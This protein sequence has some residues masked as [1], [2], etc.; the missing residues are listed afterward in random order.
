MGKRGGV[1]VFVRLGFHRARRAVGQ[2]VP[3]IGFRVA[4]AGGNAALG[5]DILDRLPRI[6]AVFRIDLRERI[7]T[8]QAGGRAGTSLRALRRRDVVRDAQ[9][10]LVRHSADPLRAR[11]VV[12]RVDA[13]A[14]HS[15]RPHYRFHLPP[16]V[17]PGGR[18]NRLRV[19]ERGLFR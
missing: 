14:V 16:I 9:L 8:R 4:A 1:R 18:W 5:L 3:A 12:V 7:R 2:S 13:V 6:R 15:R 10:Q 11:L 17:A 19:C